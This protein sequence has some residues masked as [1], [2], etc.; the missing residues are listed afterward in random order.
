MAKNRVRVVCGL[1][2]GIRAYNK[3]LQRHMMGRWQ[4]TC[5][6]GWT[7]FAGIREPLIFFKP[8]N[9]IIRAVLW[10]NDSTSWLSNDLRSQRLEAKWFV[11]RLLRWFKKEEMRN[12][13]RAMA[14]GMWWRQREHCCINRMWLLIECESWEWRGCQRERGQ[15]EEASCA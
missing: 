15:T 12:Q 14:V 10:E 5:S 9:G 3:C 11:K 8:G 7:C 1:C 4:R 13:G 6:G 2:I